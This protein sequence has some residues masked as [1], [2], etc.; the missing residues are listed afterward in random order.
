MKKLFLLSVFNCCCILM[1]F[2]Q[3]SSEIY[4]NASDE[5][6]KKNY[7]KALSLLTAAIKKDPAHVD[8]ILLKADVLTRLNR[9]QEAFDAYSEAI[10]LSPKN[11]RAY[12]NRGLLLQSIQETEFSIRDFTAAL[13]F[14]S[15]DSMRFLLLLNRGASKINIRDYQG[16]YDDFTKAYQIDSLEIGLLNNLAAVCDEVGK[17]DKTLYYLKKILTIDSTFLGAYVNIGFKYQEM[18][19]HKTAIEY[20]NKAIALEPN[21]G[22]AYSNKAFNE[23]KLGDLKNALSDIN[24]SLKLYPTNSYAFR[25][26]AL[27]YIAKND[28]S[29]ACDDI[30]KAIELGFG[31]MY[32]DEV[33]KLRDKYC[34]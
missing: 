30:N 31:K 29:K 2:S 28:I 19:D 21:D 34:R 20:F 4:K 23:Y 27:I 26:R 9:H 13:G 14:A 15:T 5:Y 12:N 33:D 3:T 32:G 22:L 18:G 25:N 17:G 7:A 10:A 11:I 1:L 16:A 8:C 24:Q 6:D